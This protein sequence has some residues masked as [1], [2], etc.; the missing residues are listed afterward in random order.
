MQCSLRTL[1]FIYVFGGLTFV[2]LVAVAV[3]AFL[4]YVSP[5]K[6]TI[7]AEKA[8]EAEKGE[9]RPATPNSTSG[10]EHREDDE[11]EGVDAHKVGWLQV[12]REYDSSIGLIGPDKIPGNSRGKYMDKMRSLLDRQDTLGPNNAGFLKVKAAMYYAVLKHG[13]VSA[14]CGLFRQPLPLR[15]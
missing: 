3:I 8:A 15:N 9:E 7:A 13:I 1:V 6:E 11:L 2:P 12:S 4:Y 5:L 14:T 10:E